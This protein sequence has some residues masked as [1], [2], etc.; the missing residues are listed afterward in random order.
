M[1]LKQEQYE[2]HIVWG[3]N[4]GDFLSAYKLRILKVEIRVSQ[5]P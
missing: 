1:K 4:M 5:M 3:L 2:I